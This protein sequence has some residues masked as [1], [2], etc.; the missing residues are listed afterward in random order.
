MENL[1]EVIGIQHLKLMENGAPKA[2]TI[3]EILE[4]LK[5]G[6]MDMVGLVSR[7]TNGV[8]VV[9]MIKKMFLAKLLSYTREQMTLNPNPVVQPELE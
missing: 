4:I 2:G 5:L 9:A 7:Q 6:K 8:L 1:R 3:R